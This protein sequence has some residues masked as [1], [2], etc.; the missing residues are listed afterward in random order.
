[1][2]CM[3]HVSVQDIDRR[4]SQCYA[5]AE[6]ERQATKAQLNMVAADEAWQGRRQAQVWHMH[7]APC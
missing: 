7:H 6:A 5:R 1:M 4:L 3:G 2:V